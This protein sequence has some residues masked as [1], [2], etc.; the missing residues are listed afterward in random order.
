M[1]GSVMFL[2]GTSVRHE[3]M[4]QR[5]FSIVTR[6]CLALPREHRRANHLKELEFITLKILKNGGTMIV[7]HIQ[8]LLGVL[9]AQMSRIIRSLENRD[10]PLVSCR[11]NPHDKRKI[12][13]CLTLAGEKALTDYE[14]LRLRGIADLLQTLSEEDLESLRILLDKLQLV[15]ERIS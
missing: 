1:K 2:N 6:F 7:G 13:V 5:L 3:E 9:P 4:A 14:N 15:P 12:D 10:R 11:I 8:R